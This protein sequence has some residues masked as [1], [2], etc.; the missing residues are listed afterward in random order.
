VGEKIGKQLA[1]R[2]AERV[3]IDDARDQ[4]VA[5]VAPR[6]WLEVATCLRDDLEMAME[7]FVDLTAV[8]YIERHPEHPRFEVVLIVRSLRKNHSLRL[9]TQV[10]EG[11]A[12]DSL[13]SVWRGAD[14]AEREVFDMFGIR[15][16]GHP[17]LRRVLLY[18]QFE[19]HP[20][21]KDYPITKTQPLVP[22]R[23]V[24]RI[25]K[26][27]PFGPDEGAPLTRIDWQKRAAGREL[28]TSPALSQQHGE[29][30]A[31]SVEPDKLPD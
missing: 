21:R 11:E 31:L 26:I 3:R 19:G 24:E 29:R 23:T 17:D 30:T 14:W 25:E 1:S 9:K 18:E 12:L 5:Q 2:F 4:V 22:Y 8:D 16:V 10:A 13:V 15:F 28:Q 7:L 6:D 20:L 27:K